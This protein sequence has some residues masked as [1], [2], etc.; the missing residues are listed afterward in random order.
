MTK[1]YSSILFDLDGTLTDPKLGITSAIRYSLSK[2]GIQI[3]NLDV[4][5][6]FIGPPLAGSFKEFYGFTDAMCTEA[7]KYYR[8]YFAERGMYENKRYEGIK[9]VLAGLKEQGA[10]LYVA[11]SKPTF[12]AEKIISYFELSEYFEFIGGSNLD[13]TRVDKGEV[14]EHVLLSC[15]LS[16]EDAVMIG[17]RKHDI[18]GAKRHGLDSIGVGY[19]Y[20]SEEELKL[21]EPTYLAGTVAELGQLLAGLVRK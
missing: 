6:P 19:G 13:N 7:I 15:G 2:F 18:I 21:A 17:D 3:D 8:E 12:F 10:S 9:E 11:T 20:G 4:L 5:D 14:I 1:T 16:A